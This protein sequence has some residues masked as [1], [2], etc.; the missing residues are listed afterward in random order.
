MKNADVEAL[1]DVLTG[2][3]RTS[4]TQPLFFRRPPDRDAF[5]GDDDL[6]DLAM[7]EG[8]WKLLCE[9]DGSDAELFD[10][11]SDPSETKN[12]A[13]ENTNIV[14][15]LKKQLLAW[16]ESMPPD[17]GATYKQRRRK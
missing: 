14:T 3:T 12:V 8:D 11:S 10:L 16:H 9:Y 15:R 6:P 1:P 17:N 5:Y 13:S 2:K 4:R 7:R